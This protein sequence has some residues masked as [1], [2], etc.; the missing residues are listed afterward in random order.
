MEKLN[1]PPFYVGQKVVCIKPIK[2]L[3]K[4]KIYTL[5]GVNKC[6]CGTTIVSWGETDGIVLGVDCHSCGR[7]NFKSREFFAD[8][9]RFAPIQ[10]S[11]FRAVS[12]EKIMQETEQIC[13]N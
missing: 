1:I 7:I 3:V 13:E 6:A 10:E 11:K 2:T 12:F 5:T 9:S 8:S 4:D